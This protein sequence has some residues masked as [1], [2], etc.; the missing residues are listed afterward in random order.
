MLSMMIALHPKS[1]YVLYLSIIPSK[2]SSF[3]RGCHYW[4]NHLKRCTP[5]ILLLCVV[6]LINFLISHHWKKAALWIGKIAPIE[7]L[8]YPSSLFVN[9]EFFW[10]SGGWK[11][12][13]NAFPKE[14]LKKSY[15]LL[16]VVLQFSLLTEESCL[17]AMLFTC[18]PLLN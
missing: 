5:P 18:L 10:H 14:Q 4:R 3:P 13:T 17:A 16:W 11:S 7:W 2:Y 15:L 12:S 1:V 9:F 6:L 8:H